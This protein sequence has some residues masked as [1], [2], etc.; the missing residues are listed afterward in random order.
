MRYVKKKK[1]RYGN[2]RYYYERR[3]RSRVRLPDPAVDQKA[4]EEAL[5]EA[6]RPMRLSLKTKAGT[7]GALYD[8]FLASPRFKALK[9]SSKT[10]YCYIINKLRKRPSVNATVKSITR[11][12][13]AKLRDEVAAKTPGSANLLVKVVRTIMNFAIEREYRTDNPA[14]RLELFK[15]TPYRA[16]T[17]EELAQFERRHP[18]G[19][20]ARLIFSLALYTG[21]RAGDIAK[22]RWEDIQ[23]GVITVVQQK[24]NTSV[25]VPIHP[26]LQAELDLIRW[27]RGPVVLSRLGKP[28]SAGHLSSFFTRQI[29]LAKMPKG[30]VLHG[31]RKTTS[32]KLAELGCSDAE[33]M[34]ITGHLTREM[35][36]LY[37]RDADRRRMAVSAMA[38]WKNRA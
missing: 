36:T 27:K 14:A 8:E 12:G 38:R 35:V 15:V 24:T 11:G 33:I 7:M 22:L 2:I 1:D 34:A 17:D 21:Q 37:T 26:K 29:D 9:P 6:D 13:I 4:F 10:G 32:R 31:L 28:R 30:C 23:D 20:P 3:G 18:P 19:S 5:R 16:W 25:W